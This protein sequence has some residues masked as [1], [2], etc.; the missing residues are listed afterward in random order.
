MSHPELTLPECRERVLANLE[1]QSEFN[2]FKASRELD[3][4]AEML[5]RNEATGAMR[6]NPEPE[7]EPEEEN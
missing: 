1:M 3:P 5:D 4:A 7:P 2:E 6:G